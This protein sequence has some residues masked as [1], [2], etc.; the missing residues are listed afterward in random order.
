MSPSKLR[1]GTFD[2]DL[3]TGELF[4]AGVPVRLQPQPAQVLRTLI[5]ARG[6]LVSRESIRRSVWGSE[7]HVDF[8]KALNYAISQVRSALRDSADSPRYIETLPKNGYRFIAPLEPSSVE[9]PS[10]TAFEPD[11]VATPAVTKP[12]S[13]S[14]LRRREFAIGAGVT[15]IGAA[16]GLWRL[17]I[18]RREQRIAIALFDNETGDTALDRYANDVTD[19]LV[20]ALT[21][22]TMGRYGIIGNA[23]VLRGRRSFRDLA[24]MAQELRAQLVILG[25]IKAEDTSRFVLAHLIRMPDET[26]L[27][28]ARLPLGEPE[29][30]AAEICKSFLPAL[31]PQ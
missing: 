25:Q 21:E 3:E 6:Q 12:K 24:T 11:V 8:D 20:V 17:L 13:Y 31:S 29:S 18:V 10:P 30:D 1:F 7:V 14:W 23:S 4:R 19:S 9:P 27:Q 16:F 5:E 2:F 22:K 15:S 28:V 26:H